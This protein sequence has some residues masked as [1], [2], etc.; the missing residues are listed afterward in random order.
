MSSTE[1]DGVI[2]KIEKLIK[3][4]K[5]IKSYPRKRRT[6]VAFKN[7]SKFF[8]QRKFQEKYIVR[9]QQ[10]DYQFY[11]D[12][13]GSRVG[14]C[15]DTVKKFEPADIEILEKVM[16]KQKSVMCHHASLVLL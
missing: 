9:M 15:L 6:T 11:E 5:K 16:C 13:K 7:S 3:N 10:L 12:Q 14:K 4:F 2:K 8:T 1:L